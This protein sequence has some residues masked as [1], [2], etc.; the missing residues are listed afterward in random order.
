M[1]RSCRSRSDSENSARKRAS[2]RKFALH[3]G[4]NRTY[5]ADIER[6]ERNV[7]LRNFVKIARGLDIPTSKLLDGID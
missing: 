3:A 2:R 6:G 7:A 4:L 1:T 5:H